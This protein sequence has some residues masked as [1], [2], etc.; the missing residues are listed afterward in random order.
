MRWSGLYRRT[1]VWSL[2][3][4]WIK[5]RSSYSK[6]IIVKDDEEEIVVVIEVLTK[7]SI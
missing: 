4:I 6:E 7:I 1:I 5:R 3:M 2:Y